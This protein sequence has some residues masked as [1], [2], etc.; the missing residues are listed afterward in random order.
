L[1]EAR[2]EL[3][4]ERG[5]VREDEFWVPQK[6][7]FDEESLDEKCGPYGLRAEV[8]AWDERSWS[9]RILEIVP[10]EDDKENVEPGGFSEK[11]DCL[12][13]FSLDDGTISSLGTKQSTATLRSLLQDDLEA[14]DNNDEESD[15]S[16]TSTPDTR[17]LPSSPTIPGEEDAEHG[18]ERQDPVTGLWHRVRYAQGH[19]DPRRTSL[20]PEERASMKKDIRE[21]ND[22]T[23]HL[24]ENIRYAQTDHHLSDKSDFSQA[25]FCKK[26]LQTISKIE[27][28][29]EVQKEITASERNR[30]QLLV[31]K[32]QWDLNGSQRLKKDIDANIARKRQKQMDLWED[33]VCAAALRGTPVVEKTNIFG[34]VQYGSDA[35]DQDVELST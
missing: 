1:A 32:M 22:S 27:I 28:E 24:W 2:I 3:K 9:P 34:S 8:T 29:W 5:S 18:Q 4:T 13:E 7:F 6:D 26:M 31:L 20:S 30:A 12:S 16:P 19:V 11:P 10:W 23:D 14:M 35:D 21:Q 25:E 15:V 33:I 17:T